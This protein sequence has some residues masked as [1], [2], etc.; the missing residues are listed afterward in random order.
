MIVDEGMG[1]SYSPQYPRANPPF[2]NINDMLKHTQR[3]FWAVNMGKPP[4]FDPVRETEYLVKGDLVD[5]E[6]DE[7]LR[8]AASTYDS[9]SDRIYPGMAGDGPRI[10]NFAPLLQLEEIRLNELVKNLL[11]ICEESL[12]APVEIEFAVTLEPGK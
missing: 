1:W 2:S 5:A 9:Q 10:L 4:A 7:V 12:A 11:R 8:Y 6:K 3:E